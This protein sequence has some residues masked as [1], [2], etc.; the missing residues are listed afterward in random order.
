[1]LG[2]LKDS[3]R[4]CHCIN[5]VSESNFDVVVL[6]KFNDWE[7]VINSKKRATCVAHYKFKVAVL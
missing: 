4:G 1:M 5:K 7:S 3:N 6:D 2:S